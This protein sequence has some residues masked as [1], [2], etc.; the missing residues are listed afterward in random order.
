MNSVHMGSVSTRTQESTEVP[1]AVSSSSFDKY[2]TDHNGVLDENE[3]ATFLNKTGQ[4]E[5]FWDANASGDI[6][7]AEFT[8]DMK[9]RDDVRSHASGNNWSK[10][11]F[12]AIDSNHDGEL[13]K[14]EWDAFGL[15]GNVF[16]QHTGGD[17]KISHEEW[18]ALVDSI[19]AQ[20]AA[21]S[22]GGGGKK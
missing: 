1:E 14:D 11:D 20:K 9:V 2:D 8:T 16:A 22:S 6:T 5:S 4:S 17:N 12:H 13:T 18:D 7:E 19:A 10:A 3:M 15:D 21:A